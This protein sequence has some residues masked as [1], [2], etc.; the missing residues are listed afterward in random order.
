MMRLVALAL[1]TI[2]FATPHLPVSHAQSSRHRVA[3]QEESTT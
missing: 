2:S 1:S 3:T